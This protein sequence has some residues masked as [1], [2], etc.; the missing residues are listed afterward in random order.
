M[1]EDALPPSG[2]VPVVVRSG[3]RNA[4][5]V[6]DQRV[7]LPKAKRFR[8]VGVVELSAEKGVVITVRN[9]G[10]DGFVILDALQ[11]VAVRE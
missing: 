5:L 3:A 11:V 9:A 4:R 10:T 6:V 7:A 1:T 8:R 2:N